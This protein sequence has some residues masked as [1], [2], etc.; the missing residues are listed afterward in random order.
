MRIL[1]NFREAEGEIKR[2]L[3][4][5]GLQIV[6]NRMQDKT[7]DFNTLELINYGYTI[8]EPR[9]E[10]LNPVM[11]W[12]EVEWVER[13]QGI[14]GNPVNPGRSFAHRTNVWDEFIEIDGRP[15]PA[16]K[17]WTDEPVPVGSITQMAYTYPERF[18][19]NWQVRKIIYELRNHPASRQ[20]FVSMWDPHQDIDRI[21]D[22][23]VPCSLGWHFMLRDGKLHMTYYMR[24]CDFMTHWHNDCWLALKL[25]H[26][27][28]KAA[29]V[30]PG[31]YC[32]FINS[33]HVYEKDVEDVF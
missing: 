9:L 29:G 1:K 20:L 19:M 11:P 24:S 17:K 23:R 10:D 28:A 15:V 30:E 4:E 33:F 5:M 3:K 26:Y 21:G 27:V 8:L 25:L 13:R 16:G 22:R 18:A 32:Q 6:A 14:E 31:Q 12:A 7:G 2:D